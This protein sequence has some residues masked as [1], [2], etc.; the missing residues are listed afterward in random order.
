MYFG[1]KWI[2]CFATM[3]ESL[4]RGEV[5]PNSGKGHKICIAKYM[6]CPNL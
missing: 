5:E 4:L 6:L 2:G 3:D 1:K